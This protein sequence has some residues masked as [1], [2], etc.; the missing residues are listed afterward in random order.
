[1]PSAKKTPRTPSARK[2]AGRAAGKAPRSAGAKRTRAAAPKGTAPAE[3]GA[4][5]DAESAAPAVARAVPTGSRRARATRSAAGGTVT[6]LQVRSG[7]QCPLRQKRILRSLGL[8]HPHHKVVRPDN[9][10]VRGMV[11]AIPHLVSI[12]EG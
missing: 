5:K 1:M 6:I 9:P 11:N 12:V 10:A 2:P 7:I 3:A 8:R 4:G